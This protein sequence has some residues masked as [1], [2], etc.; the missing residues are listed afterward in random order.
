MHIPIQVDYG[1]R[2]LVDLAEHEDEGPVRTTEIARRR[3]IPQPYLAR[4][5]HTMQRKGITKSQRGPQGGYS[6]A[7]APSEIT[8]GMVMT[9]LGGT[10]T[11]MGCLE[12]S[13]I[14]DQAP[15]CVQREVWREVEEAVQSVLDSTT[16]ASLV[17]RTSGI[18]GQAHRAVQR[19][20]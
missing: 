15:T 9:Y 3:T 11:L 7:M 17:E 1:I 10:M 4:L 20:A 5:L 14:C 19:S 2:A 8:M 12:N 18:H 16:I 6:L 13:G